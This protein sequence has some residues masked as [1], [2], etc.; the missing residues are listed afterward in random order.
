MIHVDP[1]QVASHPVPAGPP[2]LDG[3]ASARALIE[4]QLAMLTR[5]AEIGMEIAEAA[6]RQAA[7]DDRQGGSEPA[8]RGDP[9]LAF[10]RV[11]RAVRMTIALQSR[12]AKDLADLDR[13]ESQAAAAQVRAR[14]AR[15]HRLVEQAI[16]AEHA[17][18]DD[19]DDDKIERL[20]SDAWERLTDAADDLDLVA[21]HAPFAQVVAR[22]C[23][24]LRLSPEW[25]AR[26]MAA[27]GGS[28]PEPPSS[29]PNERHSRAEARRAA[30]PRTHQAPAR[31]CESRV[32]GGAAGSSALRFTSAEDDGVYLADPPCARALE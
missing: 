20:S 25:T 16:E 31:R 12:L 5:L 10:A 30:D 14:R 26:L 29:H 21:A 19:W 22:I 27:S 24:D 18:H 15:L 23:A 7:P 4:R 8:F 11:A 13:A 1:A 32:E 3:A 6:G 9:G 28:R 17:G 2:A